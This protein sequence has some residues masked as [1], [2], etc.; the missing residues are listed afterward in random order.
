MWIVDSGASKHICF[1]ANSFLSL[2][3]ITN[4]RVT[5]PNNV[6]ILVSL[7]GDV[8]LSSQL[9]L[10]DV[11]FIPQFKFNLIS[12]SALTNSSSLMVTFFPENFIIQDPS[13]PKMIGKGDKVQDL[14]VFKVAN[15]ADSFKATS[16]I[17]INAVS[18]Q[19]WHN[20]LGHLSPKRPVY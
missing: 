9:I 13:S 4:S 8:R 5:L 18:V 16:P 15:K 3:P 14:Y 20:K 7:C 19:T 10:K 6:S 1:N 12:I 11:L 2:K 17:S